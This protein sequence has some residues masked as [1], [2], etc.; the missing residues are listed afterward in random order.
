VNLFDKIFTTI[1]QIEKTKEEYNQPILS[2][3]ININKQIFEQVFKNCADITYT[4]LKLHIDEKIIEALLVYSNSLVDLNNIKENIIKPISLYSGKN[5]ITSLDKKFVLETFEDIITVNNIKRTNNLDEVIKDVLFGN[6]ILLINY[7][8][9]S[10]VL[11]TQGGESRSVTESSVESIIRGPRDSFIENINV[12]IG[13][14]RKKIKSSSLKVENMIIG[15]E[16]NTTVSI[17]YMEN[18]VNKQ[19]LIN[20]INSLKQ[21]ETEA[22]FESSYIEQY[23]EKYPFSPFPQTQITE[24]PDKVCGNLL[25][26]RITILVDG[27]PI[28]LILPI[29]FFQLFQSSED[30]YTRILSSNFT[31]LLRF[32]GFILATSLPSIYVALISFHHEMIPMNLLVDLSRTRAN[33][34]FP[35]VIE[36]LLMEAT[37]ELIR[38]A[39]N[40]LPQTIGQTIGIVGALV[41][42]DAAIQSNLASPTM[43]IVV[44]ITAIGSYIFPHYNTSYAL[45]LIRLPITIMAGIFGAFGVIIAWCWIIIHLCSIDSFGYPY[46]SSLSPLDPSILK[47]GITRGSLWPTKKSLGK[48][49]KQR[50]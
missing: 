29:T 34:P 1:K 6:T 18:K 24:K 45:R 44:A 43:V 9:N 13:L 31:R 38:E 11:S 50:K 10:L 48:S 7:C 47:D 5:N 17:I 46:L 20:I 15:S 2:N 36:A 8:S 39:S 42:G 16:T 37:I 41:I 30:Y 14:I 19:L 32:L 49:I 35:P 3:D 21:I 33:V 12:N 28:A 25:E 4:T 23:L 26:G 22:I 40:R 27:S